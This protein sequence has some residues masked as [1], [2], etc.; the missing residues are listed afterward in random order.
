MSAERANKVISITDAAGHL[1]MVDAD[2]STHY[3]AFLN[4]KWRESGDPVGAANVQVTDELRFE[5]LRDIQR[6]EELFIDYGVEYWVFQRTERDVRDIEDTAKRIRIITE[7]IDSMPNRPTPTLPS[8]HTHTTTTPEP[9]PKSKHASSARTSPA[10]P[11]HSSS[12]TTTSHSSTART[13]PKRD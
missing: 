3:S 6:G 1:H 13:K 10:S 5:C 7:T 2:S 12:A 4:H 9:N 11:T 8:S